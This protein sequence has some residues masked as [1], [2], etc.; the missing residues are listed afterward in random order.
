[1]ACLALTTTATTTAARAA[2]PAPY[3]PTAPCALSIDSATL[4]TGHTLT[5]V[6]S[7]LGAD[8][9]V[10]L[11]L[12][13]AAIALG[14]AQTDGSGGFAAV[15]LIPTTLS[16][17]RYL[18]VATS[19][20]ATCK[21]P[22]RS[23]GPGPAETSPPNGSPSGQNS[24]TTPATTPSGPTSES[25]SAPSG[26]HA[27]TSPAGPTSAPPPTSPAPGA[28]SPGHVTGPPI[29]PLLLVLAL[30]ALL[31]VGGSVLMVALTHRRRT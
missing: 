9:A 21:L 19:S 12:R 6:G 3:P 30:I 1:M 25:G 27:K 23:P 10:N 24:T 29:G 8:L 18:L 11:E 2:T 14:T 17:G 28:Q 13:P 4:S 22:A 16:P 15:V 5:V 20:S 31:V 7:G 26:H